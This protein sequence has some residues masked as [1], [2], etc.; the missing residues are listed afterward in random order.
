[1]RPLS[2]FALA[3]CTLLLAPPVAAELRVGAVVVDVTPPDMPVIVN[4]GILSRTV[5]QVKTP[6]NARAIVVDDGKQRLA[7]VVVDS[8]MMPLFLLDDAKALA[9][10]RT[11]IKPDHM[12]ISATHTHTAPSAMGALGTDADPRYVPYL[13]EKLAEAIA[14]AEAKLAPAH[15]GWTT[16]NADKFTAL[17]R[18]IR[19]PDRVD[20]DPFGNPTVRANMHSARVPENVTGPS[21][22]EDPEVSM[23]SFASPEGEPIAVLANFSMHYF[24][25]S[26]ISADY[27]GLLCNAFQDRVTQSQQPA[28]PDNSKP[29]DTATPSMVAM[30]SHGCSGDIWRRDYT[31]GP[32]GNYNPT[33]E[34]YTTELL[35]LI[36]GAFEKIEHHPVD[37]IAMAEA[38]LPLMYRLPDAQR[39]QWAQQIVESM[40]GELPKNI[41]QVYAREQVILHELQSTDVVVQGIRIGDIGI[42]TTPNETYALTGLKLK[43]QSPFAKQMVIELANGG[44]GYI[45][46]PEQHHLGGY[47]TWAARSAGL[48]VQAEPKIAEANLQLLEQLAGKPRRPF[49]QSVGKRTQAIQAADPYAF[50]RLDQMGGSIAI[51]SS[52][53][54]RDASVS[55]GY[56]LFLEGPAQPGVCEADEINRA[57]HLA[58]G[59]LQTRLPIGQSDYSVAMWIWNGMPNDGRETTGWFVSRDRP[60]Q[61]SPV[62]DHLGIGGTATTPG[63]LIFVNGNN[64][65]VTGQ[66]TLERWSWNHVVMTR[67]GDKVQV[68]LNGSKQPEI[69]TTASATGVSQVGE[70]FI[71]GRSDDDSNFEGRIDEVAI[72]DRALDQSQLETLLVEPIE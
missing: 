54:H 38:R 43:L 17:R 70:L 5:D 14:T 57:I 39:L 42:S 31:A 66:T 47:N 36:Y 9:A 20:D 58:G 2:V 61:A 52:K 18:W 48:E 22:P 51:D 62:G 28:N 4:G 55:P 21:G 56:A 37:S 63:K 3:L 23:I 6:I 59:R 12:L 34:T 50:Y 26:Q 45:P 49:V 1:M 72:F 35:D 69:E 44:D 32:D 8:C 64:P 53:H 41:E 46:P 29:Q 67:S 13:R 65:P 30:L 11:K 10:Q 27:F 71:G 40:E 16:V 33:L 24:G 68:Y 15:V 60:Y 25:D 19:R 7:I